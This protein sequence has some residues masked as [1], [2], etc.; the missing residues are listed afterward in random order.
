ME[1]TFLAAL[2]FLCAHELDAVRAKEWRMLPGL[3]RLSDP[4]GQRAFI[5]LHLPLFF[6]IFLA[7]A[8]PT[9]SWRPA[10]DTFC[11]IHL[12][13]HLLLRQRLHHDFHSPSSWLLIGGAGF[14]GAIDLALLG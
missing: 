6:L 13:L 7:I 3:C 10:L 2:A 5:L 8:D 12:V 14:F 11:M 4:A 1:A 9:T